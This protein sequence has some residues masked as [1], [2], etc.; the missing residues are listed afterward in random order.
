[1]PISRYV[2]LQSFAKCLIFQGREWA[3]SRTYPEMCLGLDPTAGF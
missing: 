2:L 1:M 3:V